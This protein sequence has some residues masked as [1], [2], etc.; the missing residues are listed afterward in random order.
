MSRQMHARLA[1]SELVVVP[2]AGHIA[3]IEQAEVFNQA[4]L[5]FLQKQ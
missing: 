3:N 4:L 2:N 5:G 1:G